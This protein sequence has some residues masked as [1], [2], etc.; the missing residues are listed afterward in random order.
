LPAVIG[1][2]FIIGLIVYLIFSPPKCITV[3]VVNS[4]NNTKSTKIGD[5]TG[6]YSRSIDLLVLDWLLQ[7]EAVAMGVVGM[8]R[9]VGMVGM[10]GMVG[11][12]GI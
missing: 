10:V 3:N 12:V 6:I 11:G 7:L 4:N 9:I 2:V 8:V 5:V 1:S